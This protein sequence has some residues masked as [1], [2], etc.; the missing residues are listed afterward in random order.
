MGTMKKSKPA[1]D[2]VDAIS[3]LEADHREARELLS[4]LSESTERA[5]Q[6]RATKLQKL[7]PALWVHMQIE[8][9]IFYPAFFE[10]RKKNDDEMHFYE[11][12]AEHQGAKAALAKLERADPATPRFR[13]LAKVVNDLIDHHATEE[14]EEMFPRAKE[15]LGKDQLREL[16]VQLA[17][18]K[19]ELLANGHY[20]RGPVE[21]VEDIESFGEDRTVALEE[22]ERS[23]PH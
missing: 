21:D 22:R 1:R 17:H 2:E 15:L 12:R 5:V 18:R 16:G 13:A 14:E 8:E 9:E 7:A 23:R 20:V 3:L 11:A 6:T 4:A 10:A 19:E